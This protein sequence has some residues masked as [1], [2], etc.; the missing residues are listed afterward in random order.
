MSSN[1]FPL[2]TIITSTFNCAE[3]LVKTA[4]SIRSQVYKS[5]EWIVIDGGSNDLTVDVIN[6][7]LDLISYWKS[8]KDFG[9]YD[10]W[11]KA[12]KYIK[13]DWVLFLGAGDVFNNSSSLNEVIKHF[14]Y[15]TNF[16]I[17]YCNVF[18][19]DKDGIIRYL[20]RKPELNYWENGRIAL[21]NHQGV[22]HSRRH[23]KDEF[24]FDSTLKIAGDTKFLMSILKTGSAKHIDLTLS[25][26]QDDGVSNNINNILIA[27]SEINRICIELGYNV[28]FINRISAFIKDYLLILFNVI[29][30]LKFIGLFK[31]S[32]DK[33]RS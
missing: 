15:E 30:P 11:N 23:F 14:P 12:T 33:V 20:S 4:N 21:P 19:T 31:G 32:F 28:P 3:S 26:M 27:R 16:D 5:I 7:N 17:I 13:G 18:I 8:E 10:A 2:I 25:Q 22:F 6:Q 24:T 9:I 1:S 29:F